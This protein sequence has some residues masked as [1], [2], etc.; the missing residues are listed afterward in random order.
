[1]RRLASAQQLTSFCTLGALRSLR[2]AKQSPNNIVRECGS[3][4]RVHYMQCTSIGN[5]IPQS[6]TPICTLDS[7]PP[8][9]SI[10]RHLPRLFTKGWSCPQSRCG[11]QSG[12][13]IHPRVHSQ[14]GHKSHCSQLPGYLDISS[15][16]NNQRRAMYFVSNPI[17]LL[18][19]Y[20]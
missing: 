13:D 20:G 9:N 2:K 15:T 3:L 1:M 18:N 4:A 16:K 19:G 8:T 12:N 6:T 14:R 7:W 10:K 5:P 17:C 11:V